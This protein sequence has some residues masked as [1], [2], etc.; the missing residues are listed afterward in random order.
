MDKLRYV[1]RNAD[2]LDEVR[3]SDVEEIEAPFYTP[4]ISGPEGLEALLLAKD[5]L[6]PDN[7]IMV[8]G[9][10]WQDIRS[11]PRFKKVK[12]EIQELV[13]EHPMFYYEPV[14]LFRYT[15]PQNLVTY[16][17]QGSQSS[18][19]EFYSELR[20]GNY[21]DAID[22]L[23]TFF[24]PFVEAQMKPLLKSKDIS[25]PSKYQSQSSGKIY[26]AWRDK[27]ADSGFTG[28]FERLATDAG[29]SRNAAVIPPVPPVMKSSGNDVINRTIG[30][31]N[32]MA[33]ICEQVWEDSSLGSVTSYF[34][35]YVD[36]GAFDP[37]GSEN[38][39]RVRRAVRQQIEPTSYQGVAI[40][41]SNLENVWEKG[42]SKALERF[43]TDI[44]NIARE[45][46]VPVIMPRS[47]Y[48]GMALT[49]QG[50]QSF[51]SLMNGNLAYNRRGGA[52]NQRAKYGTLPVYGASRDVNAEELDTVLNRNGGTLHG[53]SGLPDSP[54]TYNHSASSYEGKY[55]D[56]RQ[57]RIQF[58][59][60]RRL[61]H[62][63]EAEELRDGR[64]RGTADQA[65]RYLERGD[66]P[67]LS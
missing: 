35:V 17:L 57:F 15:R 25:V 47:G 26:E 60:Q 21:Q 12:S 23:P 2:G 16:A 4:E 54:P 45:E 64:R 58:G 32:Y 6:D 42:N 3:V 62:V 66:H 41:I 49:D 40:T 8:P 37:G 52:P 50:V 65:Q 28:Y 11:K 31:N 55:G 59:K 56:A 33:T 46:E 38:L 9:H 7:P 63:R 44:T 39:N 48:Y 36:Q 53:V 18:S 1:D 29:K 43:V 27:R 67:H 34:H 19:R 13:S 51:S 30:F 22:K 20:D 24:Q 61:V 5:A 14:E 10:R